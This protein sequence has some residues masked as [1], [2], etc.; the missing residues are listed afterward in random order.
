MLLSNSLAFTSLTGIV[1]AIIVALRSGT[2]GN[3]SRECTEDGEVEVN[4]RANVPLLFGCVQERVRQE[5]KEIR[6][7][8]AFR[9]TVYLFLVSARA[10]ADGEYQDSVRDG[11]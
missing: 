7:V 9:M 5:P 11:G 8:N 2:H 6:L 3:L 1:T 4:V 10:G